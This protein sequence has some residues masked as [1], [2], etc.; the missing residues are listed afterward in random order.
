MAVSATWTIAIDLNDDGDFADAGEDI[1]SRVMS[2][3]WQLGFS[4]PYDVIARA[5]TCEM[6]LNNSDKE[7]SPENASASIYPNFTRNKVI[8]IQST[9]SAVTRTHFIGRIASISPLGNT[10]GNRT[11]SVYCAGFLQEAQ[12][13]E[14]FVP[15]QES[16]TADQVIK[17]ILGRSNLHPPGLSGGWLLGVTNFT[18]LGTNTTL[19]E[20]TDILTAE[21]GQTTFTVIGDKWIDGVSVFGALRDTVGRE[22]G[23]LFVDRNGVLNFWN[24][25]HLAAKGAADVTINETSINAM[26]YSFG[27]GVVN[28]VT[29]KANPR[30][31]EST[32]SV[33]GQLDKAVRLK[34]GETKTINFRFQSAADGAK[35]AGRNLSA[36]IPATDYQVNNDKDGA[37]VDYTN[38]V[39][40]KIVEESATRARVEFTNKAPFEVWIQAG[41][42]VRGE[43]ITDYGIFDMTAKDSTSIGSNRRQSFT[44]PFT[45]DDVDVA[46]GMADYLLDLWANPVGR[47]TSITLPAYQSDT[48]T[49]TIGDRITLAETQTQASADYFIIGESFQLA[50]KN[51]IATWTLE[52]ADSQNYWLLGTTDFGELGTKTVI[53]PF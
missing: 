32:A 11:T 52:P 33:L 13:A 28:F 50:D 3:N 40:A 49:R 14:A 9:Y 1:T 25:H 39:D 27:D 51:V 35:I 23:R 43:K 24:R 46:Q 17:E 44:Y 19:G 21:T 5:A 42:T 26:T 8:R 41:A 4:A 22:G 31:I 6:V 20:M 29:V 2:A 45:M 53:G 38:L 10:L 15:A 12:Y 30:S 36:P 48:M 7:Y 18:E 34:V 37:G 16:K 47:I